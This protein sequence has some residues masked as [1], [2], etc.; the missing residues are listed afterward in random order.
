[1]KTEMICVNPKS[2]TAKDRFNKDMDKLHSC[3][4]I[5][6]ENGMVVLSSISN[7]YSFEMRESCDDHWEV[8]K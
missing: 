3:R 1:M 2:A 8:V 7:R 4:V 6:R 5:K